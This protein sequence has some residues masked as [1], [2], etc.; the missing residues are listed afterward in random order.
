VLVVTYKVPDAGNPAVEATLM[1]DC[2]NTAV[3]DPEAIVVLG[4][5]AVVMVA[6]LL[7]FG[8]VLK[9]CE[10]VLPAVL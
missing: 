3:L 10:E 6:A 4:S 7:V 1:V 5:V 9:F 2:G 8:R